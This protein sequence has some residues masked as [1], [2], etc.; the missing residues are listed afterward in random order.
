MNN[1][2]RRSSISDA[3]SEEENEE[4][5]YTVYE[6]PGLAPV[7]IFENKVQFRIRWP[8]KRLRH[9]KILG[10]LIILLLFDGEESSVVLSTAF[11][12]NKSSNKLGESL[13]LSF[14][15]NAT[16]VNKNGP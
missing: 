10:S 2:E 14:G 5:D 13:A 9:K 8:I 7:R 16:S 12:P 1:K 11:K 15:Q 4:G 6:C 3:E